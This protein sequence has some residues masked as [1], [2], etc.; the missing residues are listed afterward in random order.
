MLVSSHAGS[1]PIRSH[2]SRWSRAM[3]KCNPGGGGDEGSEQPEVVIAGGGRDL[4]L[5]A[6]KVSDALGGFDANFYVP[7]YLLVISDE[8]LRFEDR[9]SGSYTRDSVGEGAAQIRMNIGNSQIDLTVPD[10][11]KNF[12]DF[13]RPGSDL[14]DI[15][16][17]VDGGMR[18]SYL[19]SAFGW[20]VC[21]ESV[22][23]GKG[24]IMRCT[25]CQA[26]SWL[27]LSRSMGERRPSKKCRIDASIRLIDSHR[28]YCPY[29]SGFS[30]HPG[31]QS[32]LPGWKVVLTNVLKKATSIL[33]SS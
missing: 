11:V 6:G 25:M 33:D 1:C 32:D 16:L 10:A 7:P 22:V 20:S 5:L 2:A 29:V 8:F 19:L 21:E 17:E 26:R 27:Q 9:T 23:V 3:A 18:A 14:D 31:Q 30:F 24:A 4:E 13:L 12:C 15:F 28:V